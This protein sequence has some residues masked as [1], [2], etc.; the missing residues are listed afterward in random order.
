M[1]ERNAGQSQ[2]LHTIFIQFIGSNQAYRRHRGWV[3]IRFMLQSNDRRKGDRSSP[4]IYIVQFIGSSR[5][6]CPFRLSNWMIYWVFQLALFIRRYNRRHQQNYM[7]KN[8][9]INNLQ[10]MVLIDNETLYTCIRSCVRV[11]KVD[12][13]LKLIGTRKWNA[14]RNG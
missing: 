12:L 7:R 5:I 11:G 14:K 8:A 6:D 2:S 9:K 4:F 10:K 3:S 1:K 13:E